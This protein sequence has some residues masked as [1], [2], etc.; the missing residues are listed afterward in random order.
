MKLLLII[1]ALSTFAAVNLHLYYAL[2]A[3]TEE[4]IALVIGNLAVSGSIAYLASN[5]DE[6]KIKRHFGKE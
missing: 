3:F 2:I 6:S 5:V 4:H 1:V